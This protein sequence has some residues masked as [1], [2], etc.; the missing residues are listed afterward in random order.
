MVLEFYQVISS[1]DEQVWKAGH[2][3]TLAAEAQ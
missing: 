3:K 2:V 1:F